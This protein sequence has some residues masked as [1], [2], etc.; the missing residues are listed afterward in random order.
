[1]TNFQ[2]LTAKFLHRDLFLPI[3][4]LAGTSRFCWLCA[5][6]L[7]AELEAIGLAGQSMLTTVES[8]LSGS[9]EYSLNGG[10]RVLSFCGGLEWYVRM[11]CIL[12]EL[13]QFFNPLAFIA[14][15]H[16]LWRP[17]AKSPVHQEY[18]SE[19]IIITWWNE[20]QCHFT[21]LAIAITIPA[22]WHCDTFQAHNHRLPGRVDRE[23]KT[24]TRKEQLGK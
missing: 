6:G 9:P 8:W 24:N 21:S 16:F 14:K 12:W 5:S 22:F 15:W 17:V 4:L 3:N 20:S 10:R 1:M 13:C 2:V 19:S 18:L 7:P 11:F 23:N